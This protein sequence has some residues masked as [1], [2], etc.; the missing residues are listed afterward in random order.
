MGTGQTE[1][2]DIA[3]QLV[4]NGIRRQLSGAL[5]QFSGTLLDVGCGQM[6]YKKLVESPPSRVKRYIGLD[7]R[8]R[9]YC[10]PDLEWDG[11]TIPL[12]SESIDC[13]IAT[14]VLEHCPHPDTV[15]Q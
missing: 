2:L 11:K 7:L 15:L 9:P 13:A 6:P 8:D 3:A 14:E 1:S 10:I 12:D 4:R 5:S